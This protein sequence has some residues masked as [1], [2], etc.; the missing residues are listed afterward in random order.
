MTVWV[1]LAAGGAV[2]ALARFTVAKAVYRESHGTFPSGTLAVNVLGSFLLGLVVTGL[3]TSPFSAQLGA[4]LAIGFLGD[5]T[6]FSTFSYEAV[7]LGRDGQWPRAAI[8][9]LGSIAL[10]LTAALAGLICGALLG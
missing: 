6:T 8:Y 7:M 1:L 4:L 3:A 2:G 9:V 5:F 10:G